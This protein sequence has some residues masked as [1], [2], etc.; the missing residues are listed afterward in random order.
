MNEK[1]LEDAPHSWPLAEVPPEFAKGVMEQIKPR[2]SNNQVSQMDK[3]KS[4]LTWV[5]YALVIF[6]STLPMLGLIAYLSL[7][8]K[9]SLYLQYQWLLIQSPA[10]EPVLFAFI[11]AIV[12]LFILIFLIGLRYI[13]PRQMSMF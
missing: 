1:E 3:P 6:L 5:D 10:Y 12:M 8:R 11:G 2:Q 7:P 13:L 9:L 4:H